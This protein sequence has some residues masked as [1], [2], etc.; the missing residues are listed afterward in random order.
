MDGEEEAG[1]RRIVSIKR[2]TCIFVRRNAL[3]RV[4]HTF[5]FFVFVFIFTIIARRR[6][7]HA[8]LPS[9]ALLKRVRPDPMRE[10][11]S[12]RKMLLIFFF[13][14]GTF[15]PYFACARLMLVSSLPLVSNKHTNTV[16]MCL[17]VC[18]SVVFCI[19]NVVN[20]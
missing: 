11:R 13:S 16:C 1:E 8:L 19:F 2:S 17:S 20:K 10:I 15:C 18:L 5:F 14:D 4:R 3:A 6:H 7:D 12:S 9:A